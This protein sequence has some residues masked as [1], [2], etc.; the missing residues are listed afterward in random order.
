MFKKRWLS[1]IILFLFQSSL[2]NS[3]K[4]QENKII[5]EQRIYGAGTETI[6]RGAPYKTDEIYGFKATPNSHHELIK[7]KDGKEMHRTMAT[8][9]NDGL[10]KSS[11][12]HR[13]G[14][15]KHI[16]LIDSSMVFGEGLND[17]QTLAHLINL[18]SNTYEAYP[19]AYYGYGPQHA[20][21][22]FKQGKLPQV[23][24]EK[25]GK[26]IFFT[27]EGDILRF[28]PTINTMIYIAQHPYVEE[29]ALGNFVYRGNFLNSGPW[30]QKLVFK[31]CIPVMFCADLT[32]RFNANISDVQYA[33]IGR[34]FEDIE[35][36]YKK[37]FDVED[38]KIIFLGY[39]SEAKKLARHTKIEIIPIFDGDRDTHSDGHLKPEGMQKVADFLFKLKLIY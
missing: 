31:Y 1:I 18:K 10:R 9:G 8:I 15:T 23:I 37:Q 24:R 6:V 12:S 20:W 17:E 30:W 11:A 38:F 36:M 27:H 14:K 25:K 35:Q 7:L 4:K 2:A 22:S 32:T 26:I 19:L 3:E 29:V 13:P 39:G 28:F 16:L 34:L 33:I 21:L 5:P